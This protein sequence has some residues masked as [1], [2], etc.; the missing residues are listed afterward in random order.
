MR[1]L[2]M[3]GDQGPL[4][5]AISAFQAVL[6]R[7][8]AHALGRRS[9]SSA[10]SP[11]PVAW[12][13]WAWTIAV[14]S[15]GLL[16]A[17]SGKAVAAPIVWVEPS[18]A[19]V[20]PTAPA[21]SQTSIDL[22]AG[23]GEYE[24]FQIIVQ[25][26]AG[27][28]SNVD[29]AAPDAD[30]VEFS[31]YREHYVYLT[32]GSA[33]WATNQNKPL[34]AGWYPDGLIPFTDSDSGED[35][36]GAELD[37][38]PF[39]V[40]AGMNQAIWVDVFVRRE[41]QAGE[42]T[43]TFAVTS[44]QGDATV[45][46][47]LTV[48]NF[49]LPVAPALESSLLCWTTR[50]D[51]QTEKELL[52]HRLMPT[53]VAPSDAAGLMGQGLGAVNLGFWSG[54]D[55][56]TCSVSNPPPSASS[57]VAAAEAYPEG[58]HLYAYTAD[59]ISHCSGL[60][61][62]MQA[63]AD[64][65]HAAGVD[66]LITMPPDPDWAGVVDIWVELPKQYVLADVEAAIDRG[67]QVWS[68][69]CLQQDD[70]SPKWLLD[71]API[72]FRIQ[73]G[74]IN[75]SLGLS[76]ILYWR[77][78]YWTADPWND[79]TRYSASYPG[80]GVLVY[81]AEEVG[82]EGVVPSMRLKW[83]RDGADD[84]DYVQML[85]E[86]G[87]GEWALDVVRGVGLDWSDW[88]RD[89]E[90]LESARRQ[91]GQKL[92]EVEGPHSLD[93]TVSAS[94]LVVPSEGVV[95]L[96]ASA[97]DSLGH[98]IATWIW[99]DNGAGGTFVPSAAEQSPSY[100]APANTT[101]GDLNVELTATA[102]CAG[103]EPLVASDSVTVTVQS[104]PHVLSVTAFVSPDSVA[105]GGVALLTASAADS[106]GHEIESW[107]WSDAGAGGTFSPSPFVQSPS[108]TAPVNTSG[109][110]LTVIISVTA[111][112]DGPFAIDAVAETSLTVLP[113]GE[114]PIVEAGQPVPSVLESE[115][116][117]SLSA[118]LVGPV[119]TAGVIWH[120]ED[121]EAG[122]QFLPSADVRA[123]LYRAPKNATGAPLQVGL[124]VAA[125]CEEL[126]GT[127][128][129]STS[130]TVLPAEH[131]LTLQV[132]IDPSSVAWKGKAQL[133]AT[134]DD[135]FGHAVA[136][137]QWSDGGAEGAFVPSAFVPDPLY[138]PVPN[139]S[140]EDETVLLTVTAVCDGAPS[141]SATASAVLT[142]RAKP[143]AKAGIARR[144]KTA[145]RVADRTFSTAPM[146]KDIVVSAAFHD[147]P[148]G[149]WAAEAVGA[150][151]DG[152]IVSGYDDGSYRS[153][154][155]IARDQMAVYIARALAGGDDTT[156]V[157]PMGAS[158]RDVPAKHWAWRHIEYI[159]DAGIVAG[160]PD[161]T[162]HPAEPVTRAEM[163]AFIARCAMRL[164]GDG[165][166]GARAW[167]TVGTFPDVDPSFWAYEY[168]EY[169]AA[170]GI[171]AGYDDGSYRPH[172]MCTRA[173]VAVYLARAF[174]LVD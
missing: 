44:D 140:A 3:A 96:D 174:A 133:A 20:G 149:F 19:R 122:G 80:E 78:D 18:L 157:A 21:G 14:L 51:L 25:A 39:D 124:R 144:P 67:D 73:P 12:R 36:W 128:E 56:S 70:Y 110:G 118:T 129:D 69:N 15:T 152:G 49:E 146:P 71:Y 136:D 103:P 28:L 94:P 54:A 102:S 61:S 87:H 121:G 116:L 75:Q 143:S 125:Q 64:A 99:S 43:A 58:L 141:A 33:D 156:I 7:S 119:S 168:I 165:G 153:G 112:C 81:P 171:A 163:A 151:R 42:Y 111:T 52:R 29:V 57:V 127:L 79:L 31:L 169:L 158:F 167:P 16:T 26:P 76:G 91:L 170:A 154:A 32:R 62:T 53:F 30:D 106:L 88:T 82:L 172:S 101:G 74:F 11:P 9:H 123:P 145:L 90:A 155:P 47:N 161:G 41:A 92:D 134:A 1:G 6:R 48:W 150:C 4:A 109:E 97:V 104:V 22:Y 164:T 72:N 98:S 105:S 85:K 55:G 107:H 100:Q 135:T 13:K 8:R 50:Y 84:Y 68:Y 40:E 131:A 139:S 108:Y 117:A 10:A 77:V 142:V 23:K 66:Q 46:M 17:W 63:Y 35:L 113:G 83:L 34:G 37:A 160:F 93:I 126:A 60:L 45:A 59:E 24:S 162:Y 173:E 27:G 65:L 114:P 5:G 147:V 148:D 95:A 120:W 137:W 115:G 38:V 138:R 132:H 89:P 159:R 86:R 2:A 166:V 130:V